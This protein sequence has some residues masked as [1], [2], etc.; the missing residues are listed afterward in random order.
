[1]LTTLAVGIAL[2]TIAAVG[3]RQVMQRILLGRLRY[4]VAKLS[5]GDFGA[6]LASYHED[7]V[8]HFHEGEHRWSGVYRGRAEIER[9]LTEFVDAGIVGEIRDV[10]T[11]GPPWSMT[12]VIRFDD[13]ASAD[14][15]TIYANRAVL[16]A[17]THWGK[18]V[19]QRDF[20]ED[21][22]RIIDFDR[23]LSSREPRH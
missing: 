11:G 5:V 16:W 1:M 18:I 15:E 8:L 9:F 2:G 13:H 3:T 4:G 20:Y 22:Q 21:T 14:G 19:E 6:L 7:A 12:L 17:R 23:Q 10:W